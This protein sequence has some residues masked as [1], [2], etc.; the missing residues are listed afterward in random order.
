MTLADTPS[1]SVSATDSG[2]LSQ[3]HWVFQGASFEAADFD[4]TGAEGHMEISSLW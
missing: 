1:S 3:Q 2:A 4:L